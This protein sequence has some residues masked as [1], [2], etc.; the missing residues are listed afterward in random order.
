MLPLPL[1][2]LARLAGLL[3]LLAALSLLSTLALLLAPFPLRFPQE[4][5]LTA[6]QPVELVH[7]LPALL[8]T[9]P[10]LALLLPR[11]TLLVRVRH[12]RGRPGV[13]HGTAAPHG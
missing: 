8:V 10:L 2:A 11:S 3:A 4:L 5:V 1:L 6:G 7:H 12:H 13:C 9:L